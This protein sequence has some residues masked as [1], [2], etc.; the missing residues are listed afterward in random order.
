MSTFE[1]A[2][3]A[4]AERRVQGAS[5]FAHTTRDLLVDMAVWARDHLPAQEPT[6][7]DARAA[8]MAIAARIHNE[9]VEHIATVYD[10]LDRSWSYTEQGRAA[11]R[12]VARARQEAD[13]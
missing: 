4:E 11:L 8:G 9:T 1:D 5:R 10:A 6:E 3:G 2:A 7:A 12:G 13:R